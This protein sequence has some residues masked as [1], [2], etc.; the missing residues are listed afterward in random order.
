MSKKILTFLGKY[1]KETKYE[2][3]GNV[4]TGRV[5]AEALYQFEQF[6][7]MLVFV[8]ADARET[9]FS[10]LADLNDKRIKP[11][12]IPVGA[13]PDEMWHIF[14]IITGSVEPKDTLVFDITH[15]LRSIPFFVFIV[16]AFLKSAKQV[17]IEAVYYGAFELQNDNDGLSPV[18]D[19]SEFVSL[20]DW[21][22]ASEQFIRSGNAVAL[23]N[24]IR[25]SKP[26]YDP[27]NTAI[28][29]DG[30]PLG[31][32]AQALEDVSLALRLILPD[33]AMQ[34]S[35]D[36]QAKLGAAAPFLQ[37]YATPFTSLASQV[38]E[39]YAPL[40][41]PNP[42]DKDMFSASLIRERMLVDWYLERNLIV[43]AVAVAREWLVSWT[44]ACAGY[45]NF[46]D[47]KLRKEIELA[48]GAASKQKAKRS[49][50]FDDYIFDNGQQLIKIPAIS[51]AIDLYNDL[52]R[53]RNI[54]AHAGK[55]PSRESADTLEK[56]VRKFCSN[57]KQ[58]PLPS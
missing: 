50:A 5:F 24:L 4:F 51:R 36:L 13:T 10:V 38:S 34:A 33:R 8:T 23:A 21:L 3:K 45:G 14:E 57:L 52:G 54:L 35:E 53:V 19:L 41:L 46:Y 12:D 47:K 2:Y 27:E 15:G 1:P 37:R 16:A 7:E 42:R 31:E 32:A 43:Q 29:H 40:A 30:K 28:Y 48:L 49:G 25:Q 44:M 22:N 9:S 39:A 26:A 18:V 20:L 6:D 56:Q 58:L 11:V 17:N 55:Q